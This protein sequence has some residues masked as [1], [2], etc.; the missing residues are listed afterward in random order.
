MVVSIRMFVI[1]CRC[2]ACSS[3]VVDP[4]SFPPT[5]YVMKSSSSSSSSSF[6]SECLRLP[7]LT[8]LTMMFSESSVRFCNMLLMKTHPRRIDRALCRL[9]LGTTTSDAVL[10]YIKQNIVAR[11][12]LSIHSHSHVN[13]YEQTAFPINSKN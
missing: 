7:S 1:T 6:T 4:G 11:N 2:N 12:L 8:I 5:L 10:I 9:V 3:C 13:E